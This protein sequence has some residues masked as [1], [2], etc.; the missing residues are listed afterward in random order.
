MPSTYMKLRDDSW[1]VRTTVK[2]TPG[3]LVTVTKKS[4]ETKEER[5]KAVLYTTPE[6]V[7]ICSVVPSQAKATSGFTRSESA[8]RGFCEECGERATPGT[9][10]WETGMSH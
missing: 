10:C 9:R 1:G 7:S 6:G 4:G 8:R 2:V 3:S 5:I